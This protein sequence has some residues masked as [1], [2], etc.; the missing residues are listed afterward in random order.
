MLCQNDHDPINPQ[1]HELDNTRCSLK[2]HNHTTMLFPMHCVA[3]FSDRTNVG[4]GRKYSLLKL[5]ML[6]RERA[7]DQSHATGLRLTRTRGQKLNESEG[8][9]DLTQPQTQDNKEDASS[10][11]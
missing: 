3:L 1:G 7:N 6:D 2:H 11:F 4:I 5:Y 8:T 10:Q 9:K